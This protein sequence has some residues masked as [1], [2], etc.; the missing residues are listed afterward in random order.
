M[1]VF[2][3]MRGKQIPDYTPEMWMDGYKP[4][5]ILEAARKQMID[6]ALTETEPPAAVNINVEVNRK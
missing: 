6:N 3:K 4:Y 2:E 1:T 5:E